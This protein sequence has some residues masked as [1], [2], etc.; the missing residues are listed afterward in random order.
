MGQHIAVK[1]TRGGGPEPLVE[2]GRIYEAALGS[3]RNCSWVATRR[4]GAGFVATP[5]SRLLAFA[6]ESKGMVQA[7]TARIVCRC[8]AMPDDPFAKDM[9]GDF[10]DEFVAYW[11]VREVTHLGSMAVTQLPGMMPSGKSVADAFSGSLSFAY[12]L[13]SDGTRVP[14]GERA[15]W[16]VH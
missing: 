14:N 2:L 1:F 16:P 5:N 6:S 12:W 4:P 15:A 11:R 10:E 3:R 7:L 9:Y 8:S 13:P